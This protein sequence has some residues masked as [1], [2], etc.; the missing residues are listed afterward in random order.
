MASALW[1][2]VLVFIALRLPGGSRWARATAL[3]IAF[4]VVLGHIAELGS[5]IVRLSTV[6]GLPLTV[7]AFFYLTYLAIV[8]SSFLSR[9]HSN[10][11]TKES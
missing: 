9:R 3:V 1:V 10:S 4:L 7:M 11:G 5:G 6:S 2:A 8:E